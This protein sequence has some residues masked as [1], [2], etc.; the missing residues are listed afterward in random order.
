[1]RPGGPVRPDRAGGRLRGFGVTAP[2][3]RALRPAGPPAD[4][5][6]D[7]VA[8]RRRRRLHRAVPRLPLPRAG[9]DRRRARGIGDASCAKVAGEVLSAESGVL[10]RDRPCTPARGS[11]L[12]AVAWGTP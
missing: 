2:G 11:A 8:E 5:G 6:A 10:G 9:P 1:V 3:A 4:G 12:T 7:R